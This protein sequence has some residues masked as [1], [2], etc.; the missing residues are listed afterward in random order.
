MP[1]F[2]EAKNFPRP[3][4]N[5]L[6]FLVSSLHPFIFVSL[7]PVFDFDTVLQIMNERIGFLPL[8]QF[9]LRKDLS[10]DY[11]VNCHWAL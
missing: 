10:K 8:H 9:K 5:L 3:C 11:L 2:E 7:N 4:D 6:E 1:E